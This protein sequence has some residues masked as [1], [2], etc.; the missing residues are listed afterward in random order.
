[1]RRSSALL[2]CAPALAFA[3]SSA[4]MD[5]QTHGPVVDASGDMVTDNPPDARADGG[6]HDAGHDAMP[7][8]DA[9]HDAPA[10]DSP[11]DAAD[12]ASC[13]GTLALAGGTSSVG[14]GATSVNGGAWNVTSLTTTS[15]SSNPAIVA[16]KNSFLAVF[17]AASTILQYSAY[18]GGKWSTAANA[19]GLSCSGPPEAIGAPALAVLGS[20][21]HSVYLGTDNLFF[22]GTFSGTGWD[23]QSDPLTP[24]GGVQSFGPSA[25]AA[26][27]AGSSLVALYDG[28]DNNLYTQ[29]WSASSWATSLAVPGASVGAISP[30]LVALTGGSSDLL[31]VYENNGD[32]KLYWSARTGGSWSTPLLTDM[33]AYTLQPASLAALS[34]GKAALA[35]LGTDGNPYA[36]TFDPTASTPWS[37]PTA[38]VTGNTPLPAPPSIAAGVCGSD[39]VA[40][41]LQPAGVEIVSLAKSKW[42]SPKL[43]SGT[44]SMSFASIATS[45]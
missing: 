14:F 32:N 33:N 2:A 3:C 17:T 40:A 45:N 5:N 25:P 22:H 10:N 8:P 36:M 12:A 7:K 1:M 11:E 18:L 44:A 29:A 35:F 4:S 24:S 27:A 41:I 15:A 23:C 19:A 43:V 38:I 6:H 31:L 30:S 13:K 20:T 16:F 42:S 34:G 28:N 26:A 9:A 37:S 39:A 21:V